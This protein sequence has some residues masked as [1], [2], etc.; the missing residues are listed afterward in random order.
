[1][2]LASLLARHE[3]ILRMTVDH[4]AG[5]LREQERLLRINAQLEER[6]EALR[7]QVAVLSLELDLR[8]EEGPAAP[9]GS[10]RLP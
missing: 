5:S 2:G 1:M 10:R 6:V 8:R 3:Q 4:L 9:N 7:G